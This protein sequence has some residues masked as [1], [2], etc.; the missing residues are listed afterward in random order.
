MLRRVLPGL[1]ALLLLCGCGGETS[2]PPAD[3]EPPVKLIYYTIGGEDADLALVNGALNELLLERYGFTVE[4]HKIGWNYYTDQLNAIVN[5]DR[6]YD[7]AFAWSD[8]YVENAQSGSF[9]PLS[10]Y[11]EGEGQA[12]RQAVDPRFWTGATVDGEIYGVPTNKELATPVQFLFDREL[13]EQYGLDVSQCRTLEDLEPLLELISRKEPD[14]IPLFFDSSHV[15][16]LS[17]YGYEYACGESLPLMISVD[18]PDCRVVNYYET[19]AARQA[20]TTLRRYYTLGYIN[21]DAPLRTSFSLFEDERVFCRLG[22]GGPDSSASF[23]SGLGYPVLAVQA[24]TPTVT[25]ASTQGGIMVVNAN[26]PHPA[27]ALTFLTAVNTDPQVRNLLNYGVEGVHYEKNQSGQIRLLSDRYRGIAYTQGN[28]FILDTMEGESPDK[29]E[30]YRAFNDAA[31]S[32]PLLGFVP[33]FSGCEA[34]R[35]AVAHV[36]RTYDNALAT[37]SVDPEVFLPRLLRELEEA[38]IDELIAAIQAQADAW[39]AP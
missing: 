22:S 20:L 18:S 15:S 28:W 6:D 38:G 2:Q 30:T 5:T 34:A 27:E 10:S 19:D 16:I 35:D 11:L 12:L 14:C 23:S 36:Y 8:N 4:Y 39:T 1:L 33:D 9:F 17:L 7:V 32:S 31:T 21:A 29:W 24:S 3:A 37:G 26:S 13:V 25:S